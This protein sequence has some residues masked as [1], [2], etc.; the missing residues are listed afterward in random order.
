MQQYCTC[1]QNISPEKVGRNRAGRF[2][3]SNLQLTSSSTKQVCASTHH[4]DTHLSQSVN[5]PPSKPLSPPSVTNTKS[6]NQVDCYFSLQN[7]WN[8]ESNG[9]KRSK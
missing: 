1:I 6:S 9:Y 5:G 4:P 7:H 3:I 8:R 2:W